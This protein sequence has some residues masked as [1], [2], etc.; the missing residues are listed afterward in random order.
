MI[1]TLK[2]ATLSESKH[3]ATKKNENVSRNGKSAVAGAKDS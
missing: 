1:G 2:N 3:C